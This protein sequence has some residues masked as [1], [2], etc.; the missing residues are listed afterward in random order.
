MGLR[1]SQDDAHEALDGAGNMR[2]RK[3][4]N[5]QLHKYAINHTAPAAPTASNG[6][7]EA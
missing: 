3:E 2:P 1:D 5:E 7:E 4:H 6:E